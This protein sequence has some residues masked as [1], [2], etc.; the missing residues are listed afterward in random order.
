MKKTPG[1]I[2]AAEK[3]VPHAKGAKG[4][5]KMEVSVSK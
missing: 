5:K 2:D 3:E 4:A 1:C